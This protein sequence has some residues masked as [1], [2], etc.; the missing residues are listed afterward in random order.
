MTSS[1]ESAADS[2]STPFSAPGAGSG[3]FRQACRRL[4]LIERTWAFNSRGT[5]L[6]EVLAFWLGDQGLEL[7]GREGVN[8]PS[9]GNNEE[10]DLGAGKYRQLIRLVALH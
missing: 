5:Y 7:R 4:T 2:P 9:F 6:D 3:A 10:Q 1:G 8:E